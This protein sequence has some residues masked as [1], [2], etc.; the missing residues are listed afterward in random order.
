MPNPSSE[1]AV[2]FLAR[3]ARHDSTKKGLAAAIAGVLIAVTVEAIWPSC[4]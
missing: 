4:S 2:T 1:E 3:V